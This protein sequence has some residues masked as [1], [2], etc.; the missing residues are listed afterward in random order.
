M[1]VSTPEA[2]ALDLVRYARS[3]GGLGA[4]TTVLGELAERIEPARLV[5]AAK[6]DGELSVVQRTGYLLDHVGSKKK[7]TDALSRWLAERRPRAALLRAGG[8]REGSTD[9][10]W[11]IVANEAIE[12]DE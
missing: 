4:V 10:R 5:S 9:A 12:L 11:S 7:K 8:P 2:T 3:I 1:R 6:A